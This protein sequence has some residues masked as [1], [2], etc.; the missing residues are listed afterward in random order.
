M[1]PPPRQPG[2]ANVGAAPGV[3]P[4]RPRRNAR[5]REAAPLPAERI[6]QLPLVFDGVDRVIAPWPTHAA[7][8]PEDRR[9]LVCVLDYFRA[10]RPNCAC[11]IWRERREPVPIEAPDIGRWLARWSDGRAVYV[12]GRAASG[13]ARR[14][15]SG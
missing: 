4:G 10:A 9:R 8:T 15:S 6:E 2:G 3:R 7:M 11:C 13:A 5:P 12:A 14:R 1:S